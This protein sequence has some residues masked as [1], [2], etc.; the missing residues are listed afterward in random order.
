MARTNR[1]P[2][3]VNVTMD[4]ADILVAALNTLEGIDF[5]RDAW[6]NKAPDSY[7]V[8]ELSGQSNALWADDRMIGQCF[9]LRV[10]LYTAGGSDEWVAKVQAKLVEATDGYRLTAHDYDYGI[11]KNH[12]TWDCQIYGPLQW[13]EE[14]EDGTLG[15]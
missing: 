4:A 9:Q 10:H 3:A 11:N 13:E 6:E 2:V 1:S 12:W 5:V 15:N 7:G 14:A 8:V